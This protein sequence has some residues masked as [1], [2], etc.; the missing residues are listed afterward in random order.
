MSDAVLKVSSRSVSS[1]SQMTK[2]RNLR[3]AFTDRAL[4]EIP[5]CT[6]GILD[7]FHDLIDAILK[8]F[9]RSVRL[10]VLDEGRKFLGRKAANM[11]K[12]TL[13][14]QELEELAMILRQGILGQRAGF[15][16]VLPLVQVIIAAGICGCVILIGGDDGKIT[17]MKASKERLNVRCKGNMRP[18]VPNIATVILEGW[19]VAITM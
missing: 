4:E 10:W 7:F 14:S 2:K 8:V 3:R 6:D 9:Q 1:R 17:E 13:L 18:V 15:R 16:S 5:R 12:P 19:L 11:R